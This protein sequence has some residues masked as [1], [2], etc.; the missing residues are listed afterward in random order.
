MREEEVSNVLIETSMC[1]RAIS[2]AKC[3]VV[4][5][6]ILHSLSLWIC[7]LSIWYELDSNWTR[8]SCK[9]EIVKDDSG[10]SSTCLICTCKYK[11]TAKSKHGK[12]CSAN[13]KFD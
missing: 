8:S 10:T 3:G 4:D 11:S 2:L 6:G 9:T 13:L 12:I 1:P 7:T 5:G